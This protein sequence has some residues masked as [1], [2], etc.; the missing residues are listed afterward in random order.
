VGSESKR[1]AKAQRREARKRAEKTRRQLADYCALWMYDA[2]EA[3]F[4]KDFPRARRCFERIL[5]MRPTH[6]AANE[7]L[8]ELLFI[9]GLQADGLRHFDRLVEP[10]EFPIIDFRA[11]AACLITERFDQGAELAQ[12]FL[13]RTEDDGRMDDPR[14]KARLIHAE[15]RRLAKATRRLARQADLLTRRD[16][17][18]AAHK[19]RRPGSPI[20]GVSRE[21][22]SAAA[23][24]ARG[25]RV[26]PSSPVASPAAMPEPL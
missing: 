24:P 11:A 7:R 10:P 25:A 26:L 12:R 13:Q 6:Q 8:A 19:Q 23:N 2:E 22:T 4:A 5:H 15:C 17:R 14:A 16:E 21:P 18:A 3:W 9:D 20:P 1:R